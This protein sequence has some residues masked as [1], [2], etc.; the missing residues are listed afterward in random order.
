MT[1]DKKIEPTNPDTTT[2]EADTSVEAD[3]K[4]MGARHPRKLA[5]KTMYKRH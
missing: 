1:T 3:R 2:A 4:T 5:R